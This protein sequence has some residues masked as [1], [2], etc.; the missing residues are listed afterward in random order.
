MKDYNR[1]I[2]DKINSW[3]GKNRWLDVFGRVGAEWVIIA[4]LGWF[5]SSA[6]IIYSPNWKNAFAPIIASALVWLFAW[7]ISIA[8]GIIVREPRPQ[9]SEPLSRQLFQPLMDWKSFP[10]DH[11]MSAFLIF[12]MAIIFN[13]PGAWAL[14]VLALWVAF[15]RV[16]SGVHYPI[17][18]VG[19]ISVAAVV[20]VWTSWFI[21]LIVN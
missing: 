11:A 15:G 7:M 14:L 6:F 3:Q 1:I 10:S 20:A 21:G 19:G 2:F 16:Y 13:L 5:A 17:D 9:V 8:L 12:F 18:I 4:A